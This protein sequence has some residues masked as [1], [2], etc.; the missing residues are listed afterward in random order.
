MMVCQDIEF[1][2]V[3]RSGKIAARTTA[4]AAF[5][6]SVLEVWKRGRVV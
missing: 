2:S 4:E 5:T 1:D 6:S 3:L